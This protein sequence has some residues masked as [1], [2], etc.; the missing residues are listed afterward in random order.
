MRAVSLVLI[1]IACDEPAGPAAPETEPEPPC[2]EAIDCDEAGVCWV[3]L[4]GGP[5]LMGDSTGL[6]DD[7]E[8]PLRVV[9]V[10]TFEMMQTEATEAHHDLC[11]AAGAC[12]DPEALEPPPPP[13]CRDNPPDAAR[14]C[15]DWWMAG[16]FCAWAGGRLPSEAEWEFAARSR[17]LDRRF[18]WGSEEPTCELAVLGYAEV[19]TCGEG[20]PG[21]VCS[22]PDGVTDQGLCDMAGNIYEWVEDWYQGDYTG[23][24][25][26]GSAWLGP[27]V[28]YRVLRGG[29]LNSGEPV[30]T[31][32]RTYH[33]PEFRYSGS[34]VRCVRDHLAR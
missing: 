16:D 1:L 14:G 13:F 32:N 2:E 31:T 27:L 29:G 11:V 8:R 10:P 20:G 17:G 7:D 25:T 23:A 3:T 33:E 9:S 15:L 12:D 28:E 34:G 18:P 21:V 19:D 5:F 26:D 6:G 22:R 24:P 4:C 30:T